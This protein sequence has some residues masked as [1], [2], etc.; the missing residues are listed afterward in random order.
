MTV[1]CSKCGAIL[2]PDTAFCV[3]CGTPVVRAALAGAAGMPV[4]ANVGV[5]GFSTMRSVTYA[6]FWLR[7][8]AHLIDGLILGVAVFALVIPLLFLTGLAATLENLTHQADGQLSPA[9]IAGIFSLVFTFVAVG[10]F[11]QWLYF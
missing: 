7:F 11:L 9:A 5:A 4:L 1:Y 3:T 6:G 8:V 2:A 10:V